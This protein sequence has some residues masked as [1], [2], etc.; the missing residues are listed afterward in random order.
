MTIEDAILDSEALYERSQVRRA[1]TY[2]E[3][4]ADRDRILAL[5]R[6]NARLRGCLSDAMRALERLHAERL[7]RGVAREVKLRRAS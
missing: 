6:E 4:Y 5:E 1:A 7:R 2:A 3:R